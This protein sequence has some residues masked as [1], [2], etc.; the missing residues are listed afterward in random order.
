MTR[1]AAVA[2]ST[3]ATAASAQRVC[4]RLTASAKAMGVEGIEPP[5]VEDP[6]GTEEVYLLAATGPNRPVVGGACPTRVCQALTRWL[7]Q[8]APDGREAVLSRILESP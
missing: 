1:D 8:A 6:V 3:A 4:G 2:N 7:D 5:L